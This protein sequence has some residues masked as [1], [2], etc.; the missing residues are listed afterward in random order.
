MTTKQTK[1]TLLAAIE[2]LHLKIVFICK[3]ENE[4]RREAEYECVAQN[5]LISRLQNE[6]TKL[7]TALAQSTPPTRRTSSL[8]YRVLCVNGKE[9]LASEDFGY[10]HETARKTKVLYPAASVI[11][12]GVN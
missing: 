6:I 5:K 10:L 7:R 9:M 3:R 2:E 4:A 1:A 8:G 12:R 11:I